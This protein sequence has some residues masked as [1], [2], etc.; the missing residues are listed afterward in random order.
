MVIAEFK[1]TRGADTTFGHYFKHKIEKFP[2]YC[3]S[4]MPKTLVFMHNYV[5]TAHLDY[6]LGLQSD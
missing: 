3:H 5:Y 4:R 6:K 1:V 2:V